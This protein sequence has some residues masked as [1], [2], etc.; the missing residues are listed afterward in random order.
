MA[1]VAEAATL[2]AMVPAKLQ[3]DLA[4]PLDINCMSTTYLSL[5]VHLCSTILAA[6]FWQHYF[7]TFLLKLYK[8][9]WL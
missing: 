4:G 8:T 5:F 6:L 2:V 3:L 9:L 7:D 1:A